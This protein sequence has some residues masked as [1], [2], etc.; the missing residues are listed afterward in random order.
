LNI[1][2]LPSR[3]LIHL[4]QTRELT[5]LE[6][7]QAYLKRVENLEPKFHAFV[8]FN[9]EHLLN[10]ARAIDE[11]I[12]AEPEKWKSKTLL[13]LG[14][15]VKD[16][17]NTAEM[18]TSMGSK[19]WEGFTPGN[20]ARVVS[21]C[22]YQGA[23]LLGKTVT[24]EFAVHNPGPTI[25]PFDPLRQPGTSSSGSAVAVAV[26]M[27][28][29]AL[30]TQTAGS[31]IRPAS[32]CGVWGFKPSFGLLPR[33]GVLKTTDTLDTIGILGR[34]LDDIEL[35][36]EAMHVKGP[37][38][39]FSDQILSNPHSK[40]P[41]DRKVFKVGVVKTHTW[42]Q[43]KPYA[44]SALQT[45]A[46][47]MS[48]HKNIGVFKVEMEEF[49]LPPEFS[50]SHVVHSEIYDK[51]LS[52]YFRKEFE[53]NDLI[54]E[55]MNSMIRHGQSISPERYRAGLA[56]QIQLAKHLDVILSKYDFLVSLSVSGESPLLSEKELD[57]PSLMWT[58]CGVPSL[59]MPLNKGPNGL[60][61][62]FQMMT[63]KYFDQKLLSFVKQWIV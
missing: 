19:L 23:F 29:I 47:E 3:K 28:P 57:D 14:I 39:P 26:G 58:L 7:A 53:K 27:A 1:L 17:F 9:A 52:Y 59:N 4:V 20:D 6:C 32:Y 50:E 62:G 43:A 22:T 36:F 61:F 25:N 37:N 31:I 11:N 56:R 45:W 5:V 40:E 48:S 2:D 12:A 13:G 35:G 10:S 46:K 51:C 16:I 54:S 15:A 60:P 24:A 49:D 42:G 8:Y 38:F 18:P 63:R 34:S 30:G 44:Q 21:Y 55:T 33:T 41:N